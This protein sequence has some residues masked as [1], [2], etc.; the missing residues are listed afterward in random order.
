MT[1]ALNKAHIHIVLASPDSVERKWINFEAGAAHVRGIP[2]IPLCHSGLT[3]AQLPVPLSESKGSFSLTKE[4]FVGC[5]RRLRKP[6]APTFPEVDYAAYG[7]ESRRSRRRTEIRRQWLNQNIAI[8]LTGEP[9]PRGIGSGAI[10]NMNSHR[11]RL[12]AA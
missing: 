10:I 11:L 3:P 2:I 1:S 5:T 4:D 9:V 8:G 12:A 6:W 7:R